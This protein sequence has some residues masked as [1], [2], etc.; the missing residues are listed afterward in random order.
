MDASEK[1]NKEALPENKGFYNNLN[2]GHISEE[3]L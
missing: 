2:L 3:D 1:F